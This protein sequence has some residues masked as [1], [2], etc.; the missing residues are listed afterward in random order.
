[1]AIGDFRP[2]FGHQ[3]Q[4]I[5]DRL[6]ELVDFLRPNADKFDWFALRLQ[7]SD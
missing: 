4:A 1:M 6:S 7:Q 2:A 3:S 5:G